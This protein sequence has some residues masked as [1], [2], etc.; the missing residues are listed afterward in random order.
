M[1]ESQQRAKEAE[2]VRQAEARVREEMAAHI[3]VSPPESAMWMNRMMAEMW[4]PFI[5]PMA[6]SDNLAN[7]Q[8]WWDLW[9][10]GDPMCRPAMAKCEARGES[11]NP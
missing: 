9:S 2:A 1:R 6:L 11:T 8:V 5:V 3:P 4:L 7:W 10:Q